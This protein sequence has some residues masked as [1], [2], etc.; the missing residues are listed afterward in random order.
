MLQKLPKVKTTVQLEHAEYVQAKKSEREDNTS[1]IFENNI[2]QIIVGD[3]KEGWSRH[4]NYTSRFY[5]IRC[6]VM[7]TKVKIVYN[8]VRPKG[9]RLKRFAGTASGHESLKDMFEK[10]HSHYNKRRGEGKIGESKSSTY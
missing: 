3:S 5:G 6:I 4:L 1:I 8:Y 9:E 7:F 2:A 10:I